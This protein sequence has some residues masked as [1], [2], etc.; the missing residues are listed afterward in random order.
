MADSIPVRDGA[1]PTLFTDL[2]RAASRFGASLAE[3][4]GPMLAVHASA[5]SFG[6][7]LALDKTLAWQLHTMATAS[8]PEAVLAAMPGRMGCDKL[9]RAMRAR[10][11]DTSVVEEARAELEDVLRRRSISRIQ[12]KAL[13][14]GGTD[15]SSRKRTADQLH[16]HAFQAQSALRGVSI[17]GTIA[18][19]FMAPDATADQVRRVLISLVHHLVRSMSVGPI[20]LLHRPC[21]DN[22][23]AARGALAPRRPS[24]P[25][26][27]T[28]LC[29][30]GVGPEAISVLSMR[31][32]EVA[33]VDPPPERADGIDVAF[34]EVVTEARGGDGTGCP[35]KSITTLLALPTETA[36]CD[37][38]V[39]KS[40]S[41]GRPSVGLYFHPSP[42]WLPPGHPEFLRHPYTPDA[43]WLSDPRLTGRLSHLNGK[44]QRL[45]QVGAEMLKSRV[46][47]FDCLRIRMDYPPT[48]TGLLIRWMGL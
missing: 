30:E 21:V 48:P 25:Q 8:T 15:R 17:G 38:F 10:D 43:D 35:A 23:S 16:R 18:T 13:A 20:P 47:D 34:A 6:N 27:L 40:I 42:E 28:E 22:L 26:L 41:R 2:A 4:A 39:H 44:Y 3:C 46:E 33:C 45:L 29:S 12:L 9:V 24:S 36:V 1:K 7:A 5:R 19:T 31:D 11:L 32:V 14:L 37:V